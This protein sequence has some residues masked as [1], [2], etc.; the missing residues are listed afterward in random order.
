MRTTNLTC[1]PPG[2][3]TRLDTIRH[4]P[5]PR[6]GPAH[7]A[8]RTPRLPAATPAGARRTH[9]V[10]RH[11]TPRNRMQPVATTP[12]VQNEP[13]APPLCLRV[14][15]PHSPP[16]T[17]PRP[18]APRATVGMPLVRAHANTSPNHTNARR[19]KTKP[20]SAT[21]CNVVQRPVTQCNA[22]HQRKTIPPVPSPLCVLD[23]HCGCASSS[24]RYRPDPAKTR[25]SPPSHIEPN[26][27]RPPTLRFTPNKPEQT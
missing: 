12:K 21:P 16:T 3:S 1:H 18:P 8:A 26:L 13:A 27:S 5:R 2:P 22:S 6:A 10:Q 25:P 14:P 4:L 24:P 11:A 15:C 17:P 20:D 9:A 7:G 19:R 23:V